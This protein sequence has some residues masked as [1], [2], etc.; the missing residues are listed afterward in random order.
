[1]SLK[2]TVLVAL[3]PFALASCEQLGFDDP[4]KAAALREA[5]GRAVGSG[6]RYSGK[7][8]EECYEQSRRES[9]AAIFAGWREMDGYMRENNIEVMKSADSA[10]PMAKEKPKD[11]P[12]EN[13]EA[14]K[15]APEGG[16]M[17]KPPAKGKTDAA[18]HGKP[19]VT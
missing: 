9:K 11:K 4:A 14:A 19:S 12:A 7:S 10:E 15:K 1:M 17:E 18:L 8:L 13:P 6:C 16:A 2:R 5:E 3:L